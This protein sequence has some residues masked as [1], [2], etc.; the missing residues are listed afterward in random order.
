LKI[1]ASFRGRRVVFSMPHQS[2]TLLQPRGRPGVVTKD[3][4]SFLSIPWGRRFTNRDS[5]FRDSMFLKPFRVRDKAST[6]ECNEQGSFALLIE[7]EL[8]T[9]TRTINVIIRHVPVLYCNILLSIDT[10]KL[11]YSTILTRCGT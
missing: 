1:R 6:K 8:Q 3:D 9:M 11:H 10:S 5:M 2:N 7:A 4:E